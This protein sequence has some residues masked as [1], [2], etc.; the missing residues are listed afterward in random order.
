MG[1]NV[2][3]RFDVL[4]PFTD[5]VLSSLID[6]HE[7][8]MISVDG[9]NIFVMIDKVCAFFKHGLVKRS[10]DGQRN[11][12]AQ[13]SEMF[14]Q[15]GLLNIFFHACDAPV[16]ESALTA[17]LGC[18]RLTIT[19]RSDVFCSAFDEDAP[20]V[21]STEDFTRPKVFSSIP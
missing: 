6:A 8:G 9:Q 20:V 16:T 13:C 17:I 3:V 2:F 1:K 5:F 15:R 11:A 19:G 10:E 12:G 18:L 7:L 14:C 21:S 4:D